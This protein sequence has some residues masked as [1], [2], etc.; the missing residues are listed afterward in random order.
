[1]PLFKQIVMHCLLHQ[2]QSTNIL[3]FRLLPLT[4]MLMERLDGAETLS[5]VLTVLLDCINSWDGTS[6]LQ[7][8]AALNKEAKGGETE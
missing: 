2:L 6:M 1:M 7:P 5:E 4:A 3:S 8:T